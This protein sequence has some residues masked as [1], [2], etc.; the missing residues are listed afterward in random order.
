MTNLGAICCRIGVLNELRPLALVLRCVAIYPTPIFVVA[1]FVE[2]ECRR[3][4]DFQR[5]SP[6]SLS[7]LIAG[8]KPVKFWFD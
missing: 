8:S 2:C 1:Y 5:A 4:L 3:D 7:E 6:S